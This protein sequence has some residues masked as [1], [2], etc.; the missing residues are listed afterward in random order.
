VVWEIEED[1]TGFARMLSP[2]RA[3]FTL[4][5]RDGATLVMAESTF[6]PRN[7][8]VLT[9]PSLIRRRFHNTQQAIL[10]ALK[11]S[12]EARGGSSPLGRIETLLQTQR[13]LRL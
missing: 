11:D 4:T 13:F 5:E 2:W 6:H 12:V 8:L 1:S 7:L 3:G 9:T 10:H